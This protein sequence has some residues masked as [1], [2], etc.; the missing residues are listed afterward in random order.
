MRYTLVALPEA[1]IATKLNDLRKYFYMNNY[2]Y[3]NREPTGIIHITLAQLEM[4]QSHENILYSEIKKAWTQWEKILLKD[5]YCVNKTHDRI[6][7][8]PIFSQKYPN[9]CAQVALFFDSIELKNMTRSLHNICDTLEINNSQSYIENIKKCLPP[10]KQ[11]GPRENYIADHINTC[12]YCRIEKGAEAKEMV[13]K[14][15]QNENI[16]IFTI[17]LTDSQWKTVRTIDLI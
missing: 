14:T 8:D 7:S 3:E 12:N 4:E 15:I 10:G 13:E 17:A 9:G 6:V 16:Y 5:V 11:S 1:N 2:R